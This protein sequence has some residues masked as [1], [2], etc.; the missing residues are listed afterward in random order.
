MPLSYRQS[1]YEQT[2]R[3]KRQFLIV[4]P[5]N[6]NWIRR[7]SI[8]SVYL[9]TTQLSYFPVPTTKRL[10][11]PQVCRTLT[12]HLKK[13]I[14]YCIYKNHIAYR[15]RGNIHT[16]EFYTCAPTVPCRHYVQLDME[17]LKEL[18]KSSSSLLHY[19]HSAG[20]W[21]DSC[22]PFLQSHV[23]VI[24]SQVTGIDGQRLY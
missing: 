5:C 8:E 6:T 2:N 24:R 14:I 12:W 18:Y 11:C 13:K 21:R 3:C 1:E 9:C 4:A 15:R 16:R 17:I 22:L 10:F 20:A 7:G 19:H 23:V